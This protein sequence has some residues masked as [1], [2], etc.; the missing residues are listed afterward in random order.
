M[1]RRHVEDLSPE[2]L[3]DFKGLLDF[4]T[5]NGINERLINISENEGFILA[6]ALDVRQSVIRQI[7]L[8]NGTA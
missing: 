7:E 1:A 2:E 8:T 6:S 4:W 3:I 5:N